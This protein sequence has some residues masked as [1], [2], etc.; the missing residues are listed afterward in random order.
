MTG[1]PSEIGEAIVAARLSGR[2]IWR[3]QAER[4]PDGDPRIRVVFQLLPQP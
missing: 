1:S 3:S 4:M 2:L